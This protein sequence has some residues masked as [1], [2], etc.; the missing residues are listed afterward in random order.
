MYFAHI[1]ANMFVGYGPRIRIAA[2]KGVHILIF[3]GIFP[4]NY[5]DY[6]EISICP[7]AKQHYK[8]SSTFLF[9][10]IWEKN[11]ILCFKI[12]FSNY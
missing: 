1:Y 9:L 3:K 7:Y 4:N 10:S 8:V 12:H 5:Q 2:S 6:G 11:G